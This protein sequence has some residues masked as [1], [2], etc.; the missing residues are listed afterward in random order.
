MS[1]KLKTSGI[2]STPT[3]NITAVK[4]TSDLLETGKKTRII[5]ITSDDFTKLAARRCPFLTKFCNFFSKI[6]LTNHLIC[7]SLITSFIF[8][9][10]IIFT[11]IIAIVLL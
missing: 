2:I 5:Q 10:L 4:S 3:E 9:R 8:S 11:T 7:S 6:Y 1:K